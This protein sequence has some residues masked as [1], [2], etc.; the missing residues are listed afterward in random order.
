[1]NE[2]YRGQK[3]VSKNAAGAVKAAPGRLVKIIV[4]VAGSAGNLT[5]HDNPSAA[6]GTV[7]FTAVGTAAVGTIYDLDIPAVAGL[8]VTPGTGQTVLVVYS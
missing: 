2:T 3:R 7:L 8:Y 5:V 4:T 1:M 6:S